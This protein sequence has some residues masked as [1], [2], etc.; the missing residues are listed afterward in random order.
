[1]SGHLAMP[2]PTTAVGAPPRPRRRGVALVTVILV[3]LILMVVSAGFVGFTTQDMR[4]S[5][6]TVQA[7]TC[8]NLAEAGLNYGVYL[9]QS[10]MLIY[11]TSTLN[12][13]PSSSS[14][15]PASPGGIVNC[16][17]TLPNG[18]EHVVV[19]DVSYFNTNDNWMS[20]DRYCGSCRVTYS[21]TG[22]VS[23]GAWTIT[24]N[25]VG[26]IKAIPSGRNT[27][28]ITQYYDI[29]NTTN[30]STVLAQRTLH[31]QVVCDNNATNTS[32]K[33]QIKVGQ[34]YEE[35]R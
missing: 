24:F 11:P 35:F 10:N 1:M 21:A 20:G 18:Q 3:M 23:G 25:S 14:F 5:E 26:F 13:G 6:A 7:T 19:S 12:K 30:W 31:L 27:S 29:T 17:Q 33:N 4:A 8:Y 16:K 15:Y 32:F 9:L 2:R 34:F 28:D 22:A